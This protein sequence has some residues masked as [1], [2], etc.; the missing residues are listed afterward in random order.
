MPKTKLCSGMLIML[1]AFGMMVIGCEKAIN[2]DVTV[3]ASFSDADKNREL[4]FSD[5]KRGDRL[6]E[7][8][9]R[10]RITQEQ[11]D[12]IQ[13]GNFRDMR[14]DRR[15]GSNSDRERPFFTE[16]QITRRHFHRGNRGT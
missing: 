1:L 7:A 9:K 12:A 2:A 3:H 8:L 13:S 11:F 6:A 10:G 14:G 16:E 15:R 5:D 4:V